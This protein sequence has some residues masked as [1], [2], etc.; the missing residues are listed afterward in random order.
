MSYKTDSSI[1]T[2]KKVFCTLCFSS[3]FLFNVVIIR[4]FNTVNTGRV[5]VFV[6]LM[7]VLRYSG[8]QA[9]FVPLHRLVHTL[10]RVN[11]GQLVHTSQS[12]N[13]VW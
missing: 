5:R 9:L 11:T 3:S 6:D 13:G 1:D 2:V 10:V 7:H 4:H 8:V 12:Q